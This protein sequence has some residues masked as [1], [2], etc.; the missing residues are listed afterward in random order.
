MQEFFVEKFTA[1]NFFLFDIEQID[2]LNIGD[3]ADTVSVCVEDEEELKKAKDRKRKGRYHKINK[4]RRYQK[5]DV[6]NDEDD[7]LQIDQENAIE[8]DHI[9][10]HDDNDK[11]GDAMEG[12]EI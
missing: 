11:Q 5:N 12:D 4:K 6:D 3:I 10:N 8:T 1:N 2:Q 9:E 7:E